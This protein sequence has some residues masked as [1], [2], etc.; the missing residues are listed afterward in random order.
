MEVITRES[1]YVIS[2]NDVPYDRNKHYVCNVVASTGTQAT[3]TTFTFCTRL[4]QCS[5]K[6]LNP[7]RIVTLCRALSSSSSSTPSGTKQLSRAFSLCI[8]ILTNL[9][10]VSGL[11]FVT[12]NRMCC[13]KQNKL[14]FTFVFVRLWKLQN[15]YFK[16]VRT[17]TW[18]CNIVTLNRLIAHQICGTKCSFGTRY[19]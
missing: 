2:E 17:R 16:V 15:V 1:F 14:R 3:L 4:Y 13:Y 8:I 11:T 6:G 10:E 19:W 7:R 18:P 12:T 5:L 9:I